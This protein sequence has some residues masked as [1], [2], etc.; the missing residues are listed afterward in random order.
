MLHQTGIMVPKAVAEEPEE[1]ECIDNFSRVVAGASNWGTGPLGPWLSIGQMSEG[2]PDVA[3]PDFYA[4][5]G[6]RGLMGYQE[7]FATEA[8]GPQQGLHN[9]A[10]WPLPLRFEYVYSHEGVDEAFNTDQQIYVGPTH[11][12]DFDSYLVFATFLDDDDGGIIEFY[13]TWADNAPYIWPAINFGHPDAVDFVDIPV[14]EAASLGPWHVKVE[15]DAVGFRGKLW[16]ETLGSEP[17]EWQIRAYWTSV[18]PDTSMFRYLYLEMQTFNDDP[19]HPVY[20][21]DWFAL[22]CA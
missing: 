21:V 7:P 14:S 13:W 1:P 8:L 2:L 20:M 10:G 16:H 15:I 22:N 19:P 12:T 17:A 5:D 4:V 9:A 18:A 11:Y 6:N 3:E